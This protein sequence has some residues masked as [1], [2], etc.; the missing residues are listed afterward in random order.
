MSSRMTFDMIKITMKLFCDTTNIVTN[1]FLLYM[2]VLNWG[3]M[4]SDVFVHLVQFYIRYIFIL[5]LNTA[6]FYYSG[7][8]E[9]QFVQIKTI[10]NTVIEKLFHVTIDESSQKF[11]SVFYK[12]TRQKT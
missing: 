11:H 9:F 3:T 12:A 5:D 8:V 4:S 1:Q 6:V 7:F 10:E 2:I